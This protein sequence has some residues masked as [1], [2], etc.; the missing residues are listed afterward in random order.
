VNSEV[1]IELPGGWM[2]S[3]IITKASV[4][5]LGLAEGLQVAAVFKAS[6]V[7]VGVD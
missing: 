3:A 5:R 7:I 6:S 4:E 1:D 2:L